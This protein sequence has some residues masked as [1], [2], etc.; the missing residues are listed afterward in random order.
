MNTPD[1]DLVY[2]WCDNADPVWS[3]KRRKTAERLGIALVGDEN[4]DCRCVDNDDLLHSL[5]SADMYAPWIRKIF[6]AMDDDARPPRWLK[7]SRRLRIVRHSEF[8]PAA[9]LPSFN[10]GGF[11]N[12]LYAIPGLS[13]RFLYA[14]DDMM[15][16]RPVSPD[17]FFARDGYPICRYGGSHVDAKLKRPRTPYMSAVARAEDLLLDRFGLHGEFAKAYRMAPHHNIDA[18]LRGDYES[19]RMEFRK[20]IDLAFAFP[21]RGGNDIGR[22][23]YMGYA[24]CRGHGHFRRARLRTSLKRPWYKRFLRPGYAD[25]LL[26]LGRQWAT[27]ELSLRRF[28]PA[29]FCFNDSEKSTDEDRLWLKRFY[30]ERFPAKSCFEK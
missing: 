13:E 9:I 23:L 30:A 22:T 21:F 17:F 25:S 11:E 1:I 29:L 27:A 3:E 6:I 2:C 28:A 24:L 8:M 10:P 7:E 16:N 12:C 19:C 5:R 15:F 4:G 26:F 20:E 18:Y 14:N